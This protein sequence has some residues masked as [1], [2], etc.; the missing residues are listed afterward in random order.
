MTTTMTI[1]SV[2]P[3]TLPRQGISHINQKDTS[4]SLVSFFS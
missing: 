4:L 2:A 3:G 1:H